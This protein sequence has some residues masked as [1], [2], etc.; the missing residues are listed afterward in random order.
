MGLQGTTGDYRGLQGTTGDYR[1][2][3]GTGFPFI[4]PTRFANPGFSR[5]LG[6]ADSRDSLPSVDA[7][8]QSGSGS[9]AALRRGAGACS[10]RGTPGPAGPQGPAGASPLR[11]AV[12][13]SGKSAS[14]RVR[15]RLFPRD[16]ADRR[17]LALSGEA[18][19]RDWQDCRAQ[20]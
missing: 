15:R 13:H 1:G 10:C 11:R 6:P 12:G 18:R 5:I 4:E 16:V 2:I 20:G 7:P 19:P 9:P 14:D 3:H 17:G 8:H